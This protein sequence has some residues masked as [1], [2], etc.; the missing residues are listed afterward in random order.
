MGAPLPP[1]CRM[2]ACDRAALA[3]P[4]HYRLGLQPFI[5]KDA[6]PIRHPAGAARGARRPL[7]TSGRYKEP[8]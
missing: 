3:R 2:P 5:E 7:R 8:G 6:A 4:T 1:G